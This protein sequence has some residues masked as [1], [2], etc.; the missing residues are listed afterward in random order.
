MVET[1][2][3]LQ[4]NLARLMG[5]KRLSQRRLAEKAEVS[6]HTIF[7]AVSKGVRPRGDNLYKIANALGVTEADL[8]RSP[9]DADQPPPPAQ[10]V[11]DMTPAELEALVARASKRDNTIN[12]ENERLKAEVNRIPRVVSQNWAAASPETKAL[13]IYLLSRDTTFLEHL[14][15][16][17][18]AKILAVLRNLG[19]EIPGAPV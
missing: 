2:D 19:L 17:Q 6:P 13:C 5:E 18:Q 11:A 8:L 9:G 10:T 15:A 3:F 4:I 16:D 1:K 12:L 7:R 14:T